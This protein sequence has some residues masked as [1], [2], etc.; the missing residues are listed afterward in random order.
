M[1]V[2]VVGSWAPSLINFRGPLLAAMAARGHEVIAMASEGTAPIRAALTGL[3]VAFEE[4]P[5]QRASLDPRV[6][7]RTLRVLVQRFRALAPDLVFAYNVKPLIYA[8]LAAR[9]AGVPRRAAM[10]TGTGYAMTIAPRGARQRA[11]GLLVRE[12]HRLALAQCHT[13]VFQNPDNRALFTGL[14]LVPK[15]ARV[16]IVR[17][18][19]VDVDHFAPSPL[20]AGPLACVFLGRLMHDKGITELV[21][22]AQQVRA[23]H[24]EVAFR[25]VGWLD[26]NPESVSRADVERWVASGAIE[27]L[28]E[29][30]DVRP[31]LRAAHALILPSYG[32]GT[33]RSVL[34]AMSMGRA[35]ITTDAA[36]C[37]ETV[38]DGESGLLVPVRD[39]GALA[40]AVERLVASPALVARLATAARARAEELYDA[41][42][43]AAQMLE[44][45]G[46]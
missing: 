36:G 44:T 22:A 15:R 2:V 6:D 23:R 24:P 20:P 25:V 4:L 10:V 29:T 31:H 21:E 42:K 18:S 17:G 43:V 33:P 1:R 41:R 35:V 7:L 32:E 14:G 3:G 11:V 12:L 13:I 40:A 28:G 8:S 38:V 16:A 39:A 34:E 46:L 45:M 37:R 27:Y 9:L 19:G 30:P 5:L 26:P